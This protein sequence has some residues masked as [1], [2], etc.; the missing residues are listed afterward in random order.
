M[1]TG[2]TLYVGIPTALVNSPSVA[3]ASNI[4]STGTPGQNSAVS[5]SIGSITAGVNGGGGDVGPR[6]SSVATLISGSATSSSSFARTA[7]VGTPGKIRQLTIA[8][9]RCGNALVAWPAS[10]MVATQVVRSIAFQL[11]SWWATAAIDGASPGSRKNAPMSSATAVSPFF[12]CIFSMP[13]K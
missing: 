4:G 8:R 10:S 3:A 2:S 6:V 11:G 1:K 5:F 12:A 13:A 7:S 9:A